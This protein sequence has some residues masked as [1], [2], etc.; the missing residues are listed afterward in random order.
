M[1]TKQRHC[2]MIHP[3]VDSS[4][5]IVTASSFWWLAWRRY[6]GKKMICVLPCSGFLSELIRWRRPYHRSYILICDVVEM[7]AYSM[8]RNLT[9]CMVID[10]RNL[11]YIF[12]R[13]RITVWQFC[14][15]FQSHYSNGR[16]LVA[17]TWCIWYDRYNSYWYIN[18]IVIFAFHWKCQQGDGANLWRHVSKINRSGFEY[19]AFPAAYKTNIV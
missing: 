18:F 14:E 8:C 9:A 3:Y 17:D 11:Q 7:L 1:R 5:Y 19:R 2:F 4:N 6:L 10:L 16:Q 12:P 13:C 15:I